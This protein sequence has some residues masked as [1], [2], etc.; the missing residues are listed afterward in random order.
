[1]F[2][3]WTRRFEYLYIR[4]SFTKRHTKS[5]ETR[6]TELEA[7]EAA[8]D[9]DDDPN[10]GAPLAKKPKLDGTAKGKAAAKRK[11]K[12]SE[13]AET[14]DP[15]KDKMKSEAAAKMDALGAK[16]QKCKALKIRCDSALSRLGDLVVSADR[17][18]AWIALC[19][20]LHLVDAKRRRMSSTTLRTP[21]RFGRLGQS[22]AASTPSRR[23]TLRQRSWSATLPGR[24]RWRSSS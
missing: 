1:M 16:F 22:R 17:K 15:E 23:K 3:T 2:N 9:D 4:E 10:G 18:H 14:D 24:A 20:D 7:D 11:A 19:T 21:H 8:N 13:Q 5:W 12:G 6:E